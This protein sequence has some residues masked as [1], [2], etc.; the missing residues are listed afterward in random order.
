MEKIL[1]CTKF[2]GAGTKCARSHRDCYEEILAG[3]CEFVPDKI[4]HL[5]IFLIKGG[6]GSIKVVNP[7]EVEE[8]KAYSRARGLS[9]DECYERFGKQDDSEEDEWA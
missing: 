2:C 5:D 1:E 8:Q 6:K 4:D 9:W 7:Y 3:R